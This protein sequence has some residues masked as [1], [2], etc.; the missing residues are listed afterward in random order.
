[1]SPSNDAAERRLK[2]QCIDYGYEGD[3][4]TGLDGSTERNVAD[5]TGVA[6]LDRRRIEGQREA[7]AV[8]PQQ[9]VRFIALSSWQPMY[10]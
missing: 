10:C 3:K 2:L 9:Q 1:M 8:R 6:R 5:D 7:Y 4:S